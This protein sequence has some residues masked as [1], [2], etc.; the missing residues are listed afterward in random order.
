[1]KKFN[2]SLNGLKRIEKELGL[3][4]PNN[5]KNKKYSEEEYLTIKKTY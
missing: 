3:H 2:I 1:M 4:D 5:K